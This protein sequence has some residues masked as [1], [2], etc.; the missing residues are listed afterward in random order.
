MLQISATGGEIPD[1]ADLQ[2]FVGFF[3]YAEV[4]QHLC[5]T[6]RVFGCAEVACHRGTLCSGCGN[7]F[8][9]KKLA[10]WGMAVCRAEAHLCLGSGGWEGQLP[11][12]GVRM[13][14][15]SSWRVLTAVQ[16]FLLLACFQISLAGS[17]PQQQALDNCQADPGKQ[18]H[19][20][21][22]PEP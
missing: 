6:C 13:R 7:L 20:C 21:L 4:V 12:K 10:S 8:T 19:V 1:N 14:L 3:G 22:W 2:H 18:S 5:P 11:R 9:A 16:S 17:S 15:C